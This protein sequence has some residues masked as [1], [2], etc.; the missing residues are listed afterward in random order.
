MTKVETLIYESP[1]T[2]NDLANT[3][4]VRAK[5]IGETAGVKIAGNCWQKQIAIKLLKQAID[6]LN[7]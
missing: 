2:V 3:A 7:Q 1:V 5:Q 4:M 6:Q